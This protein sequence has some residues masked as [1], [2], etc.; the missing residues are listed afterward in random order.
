MLSLCPPYSKTFICSVQL[1][2]VPVLTTSRGSL[3]TWGIF[4]SALK[5]KNFSHQRKQWWEVLA[6]DEEQCS[7]FQTNLQDA[8]CRCSLACLLEKQTHDQ[9]RYRQ[10]PWPQWP[11]PLIVCHVM[12]FTMFFSCLGVV[13]YALLLSCFLLGTKNYTGHKILQLTEL[14]IEA[15]STKG[16]KND[17]LKDSSGVD[18]VSYRDCR[19]VLR[20]LFS[21]NVMSTSRASAISLASIWQ[22]ESLLSLKLFK[23]VCTP[24]VS[25]LS[26]S[27]ETLGLWRI[28]L[29]WLIWYKTD[30][31]RLPH[32]GQTVR[33][34]FHSALCYGHGLW[35]FLLHSKCLEGR[36]GFNNLWQLVA[37]H[38]HAIN[39]SFPSCSWQRFHS[40][41]LHML[42]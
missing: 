37:Y 15:V 22:A 20:C 8:P 14:V 39:L 10:Q 2:L 36:Q 40:Q 33:S 12:L 16:R 24:W 23:Y 41:I 11:N 6:A 30:C 19:D 34:L 42:L 9:E 31:T 25:L 29:T 13:Y 18:C 5:L 21:G 4:L 27:R 38:L 35:V 32:T 7:G 26:V 17:L 3:L 1:K 28:L